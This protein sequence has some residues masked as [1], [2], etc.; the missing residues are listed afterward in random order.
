MVHISERN[1]LI[2]EYSSERKELSFSLVI[3]VARF[4]LFT[5]QTLYLLHYSRIS[6]LGPVNCAST[7][8]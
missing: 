8:I 7:M 4:C 1:I 6:M 5:F 2:I 3:G